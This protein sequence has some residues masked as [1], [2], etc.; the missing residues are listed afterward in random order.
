[1]SSR[2]NASP[3]SDPS[4]TP[5]A[6]IGSTIVS[7]AHFMIENLSTTW[8]LILA[9]MLSVCGLFVGACHAH[10]IQFVPLKSFF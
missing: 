3:A 8:T 5:L 4:N 2:G 6:A 10:A 7:S 1:M 9:Y